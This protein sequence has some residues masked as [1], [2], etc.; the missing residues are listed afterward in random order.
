MTDA[1]RRRYNAYIHSPEWE[2]KRQVLFKKRGRRCE[3]CRKQKRILQVHH[4]TYER[5]CAERES[6]L[7]IVCLD[8]HEIA[9][10]K[11]DA[12]AYKRRWTAWAEKVYGRKWRKVLSDSQARRKF[13]KW[14]K[15]QREK[16]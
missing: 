14:L 8:C 4:L 12:N 13:E 7:Q 15:R 9:D 5:L 2:A 3:I 1:W 11:R 16:K 6:D 10:A